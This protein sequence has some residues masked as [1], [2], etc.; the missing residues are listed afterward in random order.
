MKND[1]EEKQEKKQNT[2]SNILKKAADISKQT[3]EN[4]QKS[5]SAFVEKTK[6]ESHARKIQKLN[7]LFPKEYKSKNFNIPNVIKIVDDAERRDIEL[8]DGA[9]GW[10][11]TE[12]QVEVLYLYDEAVKMSGLTFIPTATCNTVYCVYPFDRKC[13]IQADFIFSKT[14]EE[15]LA[16]LE[17]IAYSLGAKKCSIEIDYSN[18]E[19]KETFMS[20]GIRFGKQGIDGESYQGKNSL[21]KNS[22]KAVIDCEGSNTPTRPDLKWFRYDSSIKNLI[23]MRCSKDNAIKHKV[24]ELSGITSSTMSQQTAIAIDMIL[25]SSKIKTKSAIQNESK[26]EIQSKLIFDI[27]F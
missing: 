10:R 12:N 14:H 23:E 4:V 24:L 25:K 1:I 17:N 20:S 7:P 13:F 22:G 19:N 9:I 21:N 16:E 2:F 5:T 26:K 3:A 6:Q 11:G 15:K 27:E 8:C 18:Y